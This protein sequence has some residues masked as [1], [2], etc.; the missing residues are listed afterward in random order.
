MDGALEKE[1]PK[2]GA[3]RSTPS[4]VG[5]SARLI[6]HLC[7]QDHQPTD[8]DRRQT[9]GRGGKQLNRLDEGIRDRITLGRPVKGHPACLACV[10]EKVLVCALSVMA[11]RRKK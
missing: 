9:G 7:S 11:T 10:H 5:Q 8:F 1:K 2:G 4:V 6:N 3:T